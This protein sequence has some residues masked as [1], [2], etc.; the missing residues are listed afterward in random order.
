M[1]SR[2][3]SIYLHSTCIWHPGHPPLDR[4]AGFK[5][6]GI[7]RRVRGE[8]SGD[9]FKDPINNLPGHNKLKKR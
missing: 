1:L 7:H 2:E 5:G 4:G 6:Q 3:E 9:F 8:R